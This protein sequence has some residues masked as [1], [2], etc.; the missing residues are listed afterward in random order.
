MRT[1]KHPFSILVMLALAIMAFSCNKLENDEIAAPSLCGVWRSE[2][3]V[4]LMSI[5]DGRAQAAALAPRHRKT[6]R[7]H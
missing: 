7:Q 5:N 3:C 2:S 4:H 6:R 1:I